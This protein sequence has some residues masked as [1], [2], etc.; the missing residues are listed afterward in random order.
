MVT[1]KLG[2]S[3]PQSSGYRRLRPLGWAE[4]EREEGRMEGGMMR[5]VER[6]QEEGWL[7]L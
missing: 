5:C 3:P 4:R 2:C 7:L 1:R 6:R